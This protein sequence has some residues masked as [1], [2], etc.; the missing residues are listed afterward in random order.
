MTGRQWYRWNGASLELRVQVQ[1]QSKNE[2]VVEAAGDIV[3]VRVNAPPVEGKANKR[4][5][6]ILADA[7]GVA[8]S[9]VRLVHGARARRKWISIDRPER[10]PEC[11]KSALRKPSQVEKRRKPV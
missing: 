10:I 8:K 7:F 4:L 9:R 3:R 2:G 11:L 5:L 6:S 1:P